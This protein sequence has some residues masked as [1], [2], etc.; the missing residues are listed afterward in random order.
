MR[1]I[2][3]VL[4]LAVASTV[5]AQQ[6]GGS[7]RIVIR[8]PD[9]AHTAGSLNYSIGEPTAHASARLDS[10]PGDRRLLV[11]TK[12]SGCGLAHVDYIVR[13]LHNAQYMQIHVY[14]LPGDFPGI[15][16]RI[17]FTPGIVTHFDLQTITRCAI[18]A[19]TALDTI[20]CHGGFGV[21]Y[22]RRSFEPL[23][24]LPWQMPPNGEPYVATRAAGHAGGERGLHTMIRNHY[25]RGL[26]ERLGITTTITGT[27]WVETDN[28]VHEVH[29]NGSG[30]PALEQEL[31]RKLQQLRG[32]Q[33]AV[34]ERP[35]HEREPRQFQAI[36]APLA[37]SYTVSPDSIWRTITPDVMVIEPARPT[38]QDSIAITFHWLGGSCGRYRGAA[39]LQQHEPGSPFTTLLVDFSGPLGFLCE[40]IKPQR[41][42][43][44]TAPLPPGRYRI[45]MDLPPGGRTAMVGLDA[46]DVLDF[47]VR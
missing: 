22:D 36:R 29:L 32:W 39:Q 46:F 42:T 6:C 40:D 2:L 13:H 14:H 31:V 23:D 37:F 47:E 15:D 26:V 18:Q 20:A 3:F 25:D 43:F 8:T 9:D 11:L 17:P 34:V 10:V 44:R 28:T 19:R 16:L 1:S 4:L 24:L 30:D 35:T 41:F 21:L 7:H 27:A 45:R 38:P 5:C 12:H 33:C